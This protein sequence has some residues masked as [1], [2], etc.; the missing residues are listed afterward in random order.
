MIGS[1]IQDLD[2]YCLV[3]L[4]IGK[5]GGTTLRNVLEREYPDEAIYEVDDD[6]VDA[7]IKRLEDLPPE[8]KR[9][10]RLVQGHVG[11]GIHE[12]LPQR[13]QYVTMVR[14]P[15]R[16]ILSHY[17][18][19]RLNPQHHLHERVAGEG[20]SLEE[21]ARG[22]SPVEPT[23]V[24]VRKLAGLDAGDPVGPD[25]VD[26]A[27][28]NLE[29]HFLHVGVTERFDESLLLLKD[30]ISLSSASYARRNQTPKRPTKE[31]TPEGTLDVLREETQHEREV[32]EHANRL[33][34]EDIAEAREDFE[35][36]LTRFR[37]RNDLVNL[38]RTAA[39]RFARWSYYLLQRLRS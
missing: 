23:G 31:D 8:R 22:A 21:F 14:D 13:V 16:R 30:K 18:Y 4:H 29:D 11:F 39:D 15:V 35:S 1:P 34:D 27:I 26:A 37:R 9:G 3:F 17:H 28:S 20:M 19:I 7:A 5:T 10:L 38:P 24:Q 6:A 36:R 32:Y 33:L 12:A 25:A 2:G